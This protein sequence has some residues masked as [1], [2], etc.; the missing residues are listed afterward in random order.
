V[1]Y[2]SLAQLT[3]P[4]YEPEACPLCAAGAP[5]TKPGSRG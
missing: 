2:H 4:T 1:P 3:L 5:V